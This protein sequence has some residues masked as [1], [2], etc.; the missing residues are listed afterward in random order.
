MARTYT[1]VRIKS[2]LGPGVVRGEERG[3]KG[4][5][6]SLIFNRDCKQLAAVYLPSKYQTK[7]GTILRKINRN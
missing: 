4:S 7:L 1:H 2:Q 3:P 5:S 6:S